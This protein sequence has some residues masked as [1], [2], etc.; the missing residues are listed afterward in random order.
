[1]LGTQAELLG[2]TG[3]ANPFADPHESL[4][5]SSLA[6]ARLIAPGRAPAP[7][8]GGAAGGASPL[9]PP[10]PSTSAALS[11]SSWAAPRRAEGECGPGTPARPFG[12]GAGGRG[13]APRAWLLRVSR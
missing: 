9:P 7:P 3:M 13:D 8:A 6:A 2:D 11:R 12:S 4:S 1:M 10:A 5:H